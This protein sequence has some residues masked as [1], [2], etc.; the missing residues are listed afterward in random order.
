MDC[1]RNVRHDEDMTDTESKNILITGGNKGIGFETARQLAQQGHTIWLG[2]RDE[3]RGRAAARQLAGD[4]DV[5]FLSLDV[6]D[7]AS[8]TAAAKHLDQ[9]IGAL[10]VLINNAGIAPTAGEGLPSS[11]DPDTIRAD[12]DVNFFG[13]L[14]VVQAFLPLIRPA[15]AGRIVNVSTTLG[16]I[17]TLTAESSILAQ[18]PLFAYPASKTMLNSL[19]GWLANELRSSGIKVNSVCPGENAT[20]MN[21]SPAA[22]PASEG[23]RVVVKAATLG[24][25]GPTGTFFDIN[26]PVPW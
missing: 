11:V 25:D 22:Q 6:T 12:L 13:A 9:E 5:R 16:S 10:D 20:D 7:D 21:S 15:E 19:T 26:G 1:T 24:A 3:T 2:C 14:R 18:F 4:G 17:G 8:V 23:A